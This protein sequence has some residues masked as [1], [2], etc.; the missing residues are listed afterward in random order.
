MQEEGTV[1]VPEAVRC[2]VLPEGRR[3]GDREAG[4]QSRYRGY[5]T[6]WR[7]QR[8]WRSKQV[9]GIQD[10]VE[11]TEK[12]AVKAGTGDAGRDSGR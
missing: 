9:Q 5:R 10:G 1:G 8:N 4:R 7:R 11:E 3:G 12:L 6:G 2:A